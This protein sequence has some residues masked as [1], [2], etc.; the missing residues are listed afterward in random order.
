MLHFDWMKAHKKEIRLLLVV[1]LILAVCLLVSGMRR[2]RFLIKEDSAVVAVERES[3]EQAL[4][5][6]LEVEAEKDGE[7]LRYEV[8][9]SLQGSA[10]DTG[11]AE[12]EAGGKAETETKERLLED[13]IMAVVEQLETSEEIRLSLPEKLEDGTKLRW[14]G[15]KDLRFLLVFLLLP[16]C[17][18]YIYETE[19]QKEKEKRKRQEEEIR[20]NLPSFLDQLLLLLNCGM[21]FHDAFYR[22]EAGYAARGKKDAFC[23]LLGRIRKEADESGFMVVTIM[24]SQTREVAVREYVRLVNILMDHQHRGVNLE[25]KLQAEGRLL[26]EGRKAAA[27]QKGKEMETKMTFPLALLLLVLMIV[28]G[29]PA[30]MNM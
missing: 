4:S 26:W 20:R 22:I 13:A 25:E 29:M 14:K 7:T 16:V 28:A 9:L 12:P 10:E 1:T 30:L 6:P 11:E 17:L 5:L 24:E 21:I 15:Q 8:I 18:L 3:L 2:D 23:E 27:M 19:R